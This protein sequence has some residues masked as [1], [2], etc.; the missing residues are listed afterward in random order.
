V[1]FTSR[2]TLARL[3]LAQRRALREAAAA[4][5]DPETKVL[6]SYED[7]VPQ[8]DCSQ[9][10]LR[11]VAAT[12]ADLAALRLAVRPVYEHLERDP[13]TR[14][15]IS[16]IERLRE[17]LGASTSVVPRCAS[18]VPA[19]TVAAATPV[20]GTYKV[21]VRRAQ[22]PATTRVPEQYG[23]WQIVLDRGLFRLS[24]DSDTSSWVA[25]GRVRLSGET[26]TWTFDNA[27][28]W[29]PHGAPDG[30]PVAEGDKV[31]FHW[32]RS[33]RSLT[34]TSA[35][36]PLPG[37]S[38]HPLERVAEA[39]S[40]E[41]LENPSVLQGTWA[42]NL[43]PALLLAHH[44]DPSSIPDNAGPMRLT[45]HGNHYRWTQQAPDGFHWS[46][47]SIRFAG[48]TLELDERQSEQGPSGGREFLRWSVFHNRLTF[49]AA[50]GTSPYMWGYMAWHRMS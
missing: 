19:T 13:Q 8:G 17:E 34:L 37:L 39:P 29:G 21:T 35:K 47:G 49:R 16:R 43:T 46:V 31:V 22:L 44:V 23:V 26:M 38:I 10:R 4:D 25:D 1:I 40:Q 3:T 27:H 48:D 32:R 9:R 5:L 41:P 50:P 30:V 20:D 6:A 15:F 12:S 45:V 24:A 18:T 33:G 28:D 2:R 7:S 36:G 14:R 11:F 42:A